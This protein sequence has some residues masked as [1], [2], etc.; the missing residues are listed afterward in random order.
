MA[1]NRTKRSKGAKNVPVDTDNAA[2]SSLNTAFISKI[3]VSRSPSPT[4]AVGM[5]HCEIEINSALPTTKPDTANYI[6]VPETA[7]FTFAVPSAVSI[8]PA[9]SP[10]PDMSIPLRAVARPAR[11]STCVANEEVE[12][13]AAGVSSMADSMATLAAG[14]TAIA[15]S[16]QANLV[17]QTEIVEAQK[18]L[19]HEQ[20]LLREMQHG[21][22]EALGLTVEEAARKAM[23]G[24][25]ESIVQEV[26]SIVAAAAKE[27]GDTV[28]V[29]QIKESILEEVKKLRKCLQGINFVDEGVA[30]DEYD[31]A[32]IEI[33]FP[34]GD[35]PGE[36][37]TAVGSKLVEDKNAVG[38]GVVEGIVQARGPRGGPGGGP[39][40]GWCAVM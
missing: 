36:D 12:G 2:M 9:Q 18:K 16:V 3:P 8:F 21:F 28:E 11:M 37:E 27:S 5:K 38:E 25:K 19:A 39:G 23:E 33:M 29:T 24:V 10:P 30:V 40:G 26:K 13:I 31:D 15:N 35:C 4:K 14:M 34:Q 7:A 32:V 1:N 6:K 22:G 17:L 20:K